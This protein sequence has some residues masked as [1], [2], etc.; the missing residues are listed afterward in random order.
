LTVIKSFIQKLHKPPTAIDIVLLSLFTIFIVF[1]PFF[2][3]KEIHV[4]EVGLYLPCAD[5]IFRG[6]VPFRDFFYLRGP[7]EIYMITGFMAMFGK[8]LASLY[9]Y[10]YMG[11]ILTLLLGPMIGKELYRTRYFLYAMSLVYVAKTFPRIAFIDWG[12][13]RYAWGLLAILFM[14]R[15]FS[16]EGMKTFRFIFLSGI[17]TAFGLLTSVE[18]GIYAIVAFIGTSIAALCLRFHN[19][20]SFFK[21]LL[22]YTAGFGLIVLPYGGYL[23]YVGALAPYLEITQAVVTKLTEVTGHHNI[24]ENITGFSQA[25]TLMFSFN[26]D[27]FRQMTPAYLYFFLMGY[28]IYQ[29]RKKTIGQ[30]HLNVICIGLYGFAMYVSAFRSIGGPQFEMAL[31]PDKILLFYLLER[32]YFVLLKKKEKLGVN[33]VS[34]FSY[35]QNNFKRSIRFLGILFLLIVFFILSFGVSFEHFNKR[36]FA[37][38]AVRN[39]CLGNDI[40]SLKFLAYI[41]HKKVK[42]PRTRGIVT[43]AGT[44]QD[45]EEVVAFIETHTSANDQV[46]THPFNA[47]YNFFFNRPFVGKYPVFSFAWLSEKWNSKFIEDLTSARPK[48]IIWP[49]RLSQMEAMLLG[50]PP[51]IP[52]YREILSIIHAHYKLVK[53]STFSDIYARGDIAQ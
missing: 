34:I 38:R 30:E 44:A 26:D 43:V 16:L 35:R 50:Y 46:L 2:L 4:F 20:R 53:E 23:L 40:E 5:A 52:K 51:N 36:F 37:F 22:Y 25:V 12:G 41:P 45:I 14:C 9:L 29:L 33:A 7:F 17:F 49:K 10:F 8:Q 13:M 11:T 3:E 48:Y 31:Q 19:K 32:F 27:L 39:F 18:I 6:M 15:F 28:I 21:S 1:D 42:T 24:L 47:A